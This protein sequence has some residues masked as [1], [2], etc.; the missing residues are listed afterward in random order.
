[1]QLS[2]HQHQIFSTASCN[3]P[4]QQAPGAKPLHGQRHS[5]EPGRVRTHNLLCLVGDP[6]QVVQ[7]GSQS[8]KVLALEV[9]YHPACLLEAAMPVLQELADKI[10]ATVGPPTAAQAG[11]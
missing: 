6:L 10:I 11:S 4:A 3:F 2:A 8:N 7:H 5:S 9:N 1:M